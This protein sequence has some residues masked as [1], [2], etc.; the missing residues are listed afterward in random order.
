MTWSESI[1]KIPTAFVAGAWVVNTCA[2][3]REQVVLQRVANP[4]GATSERS[5]HKGPDRLGAAAA[6]AARG[7]VAGA[8]AMATPPRRVRR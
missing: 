1:P 4:V 5:Q 8:R 2:R 7:P 6:D 3:R